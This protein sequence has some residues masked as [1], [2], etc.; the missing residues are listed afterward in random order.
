MTT[1]HKSL[2]EKGY[3]HLELGAMLMGIGQQLLEPK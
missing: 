2:V 1:L 3:S